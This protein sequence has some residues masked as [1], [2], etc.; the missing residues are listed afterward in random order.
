MSFNIVSEENFYYI[1]LLQENEWL[2]LVVGNEKASSAYREQSPS[3]LRQ[4]LWVKSEARKD[5]QDRNS[6]WCILC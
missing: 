3:Y 4:E 2:T 5:I 6:E 1:W